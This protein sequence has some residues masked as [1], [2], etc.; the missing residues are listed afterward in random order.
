MLVWHR[1]CDQTDRE[2]QQR[3]GQREEVTIFST[4][5]H[6]WGVQQSG[7][8]G[9]LKGKSHLRSAQHCS[10]WVSEWSPSLSS[11]MTVPTPLMRHRKGGAWNDVSHYLRIRILRVRYK[12]QSTSSHVQ[13]DLVSKADSHVSLCLTYLVTNTESFIW[14]RVRASWT[15]SCVSPEAAQITC[16]THRWHHLYSQ[17]ANAAK[18][19]WTLPLSQNQELSPALC[20]DTAQLCSPLNDLPPS[21][22][23][24]QIIFTLSVLHHCCTHRTNTHR[25]N[26]HK[27]N[28]HVPA[29]AAVCCCSSASSPVSCR[30]P[31]PPPLVLYLLLSI[32]SALSVMQSDVTA[33]RTH[34]HTHRPWRE[35]TISPMTSFINR[36][37]PED[38]ASAVSLTQTAET[39]WALCGRNNPG[40]TSHQVTHELCR[41]RC[42]T[43]C[44]WWR[45]L[46]RCLVVARQQE[47]W[48]GHMKR[49]NQNH[50]F[51]FLFCRCLNS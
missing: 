30:P 42:F 51:N 29:V 14:I 3:G 9:P 12:P 21:E 6:S 43:N 41:S 13:T 7:S 32:S 2:L 18:K 38:S 23:S 40:A 49:I 50:T 1:G 5:V 36:F 35:Y 46:V 47:S 45:C 28:T 20:V 34:T 16:W 8:S 39:Q 37:L 33:L 10:D 22:T 27:T 25:T 26:T 17:S 4:S 48:A 11:R 31:P 19:C 24:L 15:T 44:C